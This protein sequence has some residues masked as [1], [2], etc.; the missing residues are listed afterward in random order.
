M[1][2]VSASREDSVVGERSPPGRDV[3][4]ILNAKRGSI[5]T[6]LPLSSYPLRMYNLGEIGRP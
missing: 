5:S 2:L 6:G 1:Q 3:A 4:R